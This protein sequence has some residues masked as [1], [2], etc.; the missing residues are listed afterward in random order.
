[1]IRSILTLY[2][3]SLTLVFGTI[4]AYASSSPIL[5]QDK[6]LVVD[7]VK[8]IHSFVMIKAK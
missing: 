4:Q 3:F 5:F 1:M 6:I 8:M 2:I 7:N